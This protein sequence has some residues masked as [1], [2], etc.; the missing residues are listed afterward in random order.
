MT[1]QHQG[2]ADDDEYVVFLEG[3]VDKLVNEVRTL[4]SR[5]AHSTCGWEEGKSAQTES[6]VQVDR[7]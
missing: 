2:D 5:A 7:G 4:K 6:N 3:K 1:S